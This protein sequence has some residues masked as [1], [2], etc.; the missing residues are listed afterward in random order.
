MELYDLSKLWKVI[1]EQTANK[2]GNFWRSITRG[3][4]GLP[5]TV[6]VKYTWDILK[7]KKF[8]KKHLPDSKIIISN[9]IERLDNG[10]VVVTAK[11]LKEQLLCLWIDIANNSNISKESLDKKELYRNPIQEV[12]VS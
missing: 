1:T 5:Q 3:H 8:I 9:I 6:T 10:K 12:L 2:I 7:M 4:V 11:W